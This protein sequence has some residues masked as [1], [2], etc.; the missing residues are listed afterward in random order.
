RQIRRALQG[1]L[2]RFPRE[3]YTFRVA[4][5]GEV[6]TNP[7]LGRPAV[8]PPLPQPRAPIVPHEKNST[9]ADDKKATAAPRED[10]PHV[11]DVTTSAAPSSRVTPRGVVGLFGDST[12]SGSSPSDGLSSD[13]DLMTPPGFKLRHGSERY[14]MNPEVEG[15]AEL[16]RQMVQLLEE[17]EEKKNHR[18]YAAWQ[19]Q[20]VKKNVIG[21]VLKDDGSDEVKRLNKIIASAVRAPAGSTND[22]ESVAKYEYNSQIWLPLDA[23]TETEFLA[24]L[25][26]TICNLPE[27]LKKK[28]ISVAV[29]RS[30]AQL[31][32][33]HKP[34]ALK[35]DAKNTKLD[36][37]V[38]LKEDAQN[39]ESAD[40]QEGASVEGAEQRQ[41]RKDVSQN[42]PEEDCEVTI[43]GVKVKY[44][45]QGITFQDHNAIPEQPDIQNDNSPPSGPQP[46]RSSQPHASPTP[47]QVVQPPGTALRSRSARRDIKKSSTLDDENLTIEATDEAI[48]VHLDDKL[49][50]FIAKEREKQQKEKAA[51][52]AKKYK[53]HT[54][55]KV[56]RH[57]TR[58]TGRKT[59]FV[60][61]P[62][63][64][65]WM[66][67]SDF[68][69]VFRLAAR[70]V[71]SDVCVPDDPRTRIVVEKVWATLQ[72]AV[73]QCRRVAGTAVLLPLHSRQGAKKEYEGKSYASLSGNAPIRGVPYLMWFVGLAFAGNRDLA[74]REIQYLWPKSVP[75]DADF[76][77]KNTGEEDAVG[78]PPTKQAEE[79]K[80]SP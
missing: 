6:A 49:Q 20:W 40:M 59:S 30:Y 47:A 78:Q 29:D 3:A 22:T 67:W 66:P 62:P 17:A 5:D 68:E 34:V 44:M 71:V 32:P 15:H 23:I 69:E 74:F 31:H 56:W 58:Y 53:K 35:E 43:N 79:M 14:D 75:V 26:T 73:P 57:G 10:L 51:K 9:G 18:A 60:V 13:S 72:L 42:A 39:A 46:K 2:T 63:E 50:T 41:V 7:V 55:I 16:C 8:V 76:E 21:V 54:Q 11:A 38:L 4:L 33:L 64:Q 24:F 25:S 36:E 37:S 80:S 48:L 27:E 77:K 61:A 70:A 12:A 28:I 1:R 19:K 65:Q 45:I 52:A